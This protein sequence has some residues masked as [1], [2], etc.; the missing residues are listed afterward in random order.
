[1]RQRRKPSRLAKVVVYGFLGALALAMVLV[2]AALGTQIIDRYTA[3]A[4]WGSSPMWVDTPEVAPGGRILLRVENEDAVD[5]ELRAP[6]D[7]TPGQELPVAAEV[8]V[9]IARESGR[10]TSRNQSSFDTPTATIDVLTPDGVRWRRVKRAVWAMGALML[11]GVVALIAGRRHG[12]SLRLPHGSDAVRLIAVLGLIAM[13]AL[14]AIGRVVFTRP[15]ARSLTCTSSWLSLPL[16]ML[17]IVLPVL[18]FAL[19][20]R[21]A[22]AAALPRMRAQSRGRD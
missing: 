9:E 10:G 8:D 14:A 16:A 22:A 6:D 7:V 21:R 17:W 3:T 18:A 11:L 5:V 19:A 20:R 13:C 2:A 1:M 4:S 12:R 15:I